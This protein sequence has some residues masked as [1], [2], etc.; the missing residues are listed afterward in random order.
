[1]G[2]NLSF[3]TCIEL[4]FYNII[5][6]GDTLQIVNVGKVGNTNWSK[7][8]YMVEDIKEKLHF[9][10]RK[11]GAIF[12]LTSNVSIFAMHPQTSKFKN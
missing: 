7:F 10:P 12:N 11:F 2:L 6:E 8:R 4:G 1:M 9:T 5:V 3:N